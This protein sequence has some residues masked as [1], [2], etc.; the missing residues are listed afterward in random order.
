MTE[1]A[2]QQ[3][4]HR[5]KSLDFFFNT[6][7]S[8]T[9]SRTLIHSFW[10]SSKVLNI[11]HRVNRPH[12]ILSWQSLIVPKLCSSESFLPLA[13]S[14][15]HLWLELTLPWIGSVPTEGQYYQCLCHTGYFG[16]LPVLLI[17]AVHQGK[18]NHRRKKDGPEAF[19]HCSEPGRG[20]RRIWVKGSLQSYHRTPWL[21]FKVQKP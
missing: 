20:K 13:Q 21:W 17:S 8:M 16:T 5:S 15:R 18:P 1:S 3:Y 19:P 11:W 7:L 9:S 2:Y 14:G 10:I 4:K 12:V 6:P